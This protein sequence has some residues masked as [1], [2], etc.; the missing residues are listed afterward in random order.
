[1]EL[2][3]PELLKEW[4]A[5]KFR[6]VYYLFGEESAAKS[7]AVLKLKELFKADDFNLFEFSGDP[8][9][10]APAILSEALTLPVFSDRRLVVVRNPKIPAEARA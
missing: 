1:M 9:S 6:P 2:R 5:G 4:Q 7:D 3:P 10:E 8:G